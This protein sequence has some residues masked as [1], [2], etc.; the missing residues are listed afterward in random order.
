MACRRER[1]DGA[2]QSGKV[3]RGGSNGRGARRLLRER[4][5]LQ[6][7]A[8][9]QAMRPLRD[10]QQQGI[11]IFY[12]AGAVGGLGLAFC[13]NEFASIRGTSVAPSSALK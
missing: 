12:F 5:D 13:L 2:S 3:R 9:G 7:G 4:E 11:L 8:R 6:S 1:I 10:V